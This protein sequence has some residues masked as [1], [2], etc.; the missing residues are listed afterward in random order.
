MNANTL[1][2]W[3]WRL[4]SGDARKEAWAAGRAA[5][6]IAP[7]PDADKRAPAVK[8]ERA[9]QAATRADPIAPMK[10]VE[11]TA[12]PPPNAI[13]EVRVRVASLV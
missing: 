11:L 8:E 2:G 4:G 10:F 6:E 13:H 12:K 5:L 7:A 1:A 9:P 3:R